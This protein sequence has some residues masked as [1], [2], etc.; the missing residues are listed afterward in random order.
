MF[1]NTYPPQGWGKRKKKSISKLAHQWSEHC[2]VYFFPIT[3]SFWIIFFN[4][5]ST[6]VNINLSPA[7]RWTNR[8]SSY[9]TRLLEH[10]KSSRHTR[11]V[12]GCAPNSIPDESIVFET[13]AWPPAD[14]SRPQTLS[15][16]GGDR[17]LQDSACVALVSQH[18]GGTKTPTHQ[19]KTRTQARV[20][21]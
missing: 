8:S 16:V 15:R 10:Q 9:H 7:P 12:V 19:K 1:S 18:S 4:I 6:H 14:L 2:G 20:L 13:G 11:I 3:P 17:P 21:D 5:D